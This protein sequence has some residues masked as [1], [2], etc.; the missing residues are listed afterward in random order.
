METV[1]RRFTD[2]DGGQETFWVRFRWHGREIRKSARTSSKAVAQQYLAQL[3]EE[4]RRLDRGGRPRRSYKEALERFC[5]EYLPTLKPATQGRYRSSFKNLGT[6]IDRLY[7]DEITKGRLADYVTARRK[8]KV[9]G[10][11]IRRD[12]AALS[13]LC[14]FAV[15]IDLIETHPLKAFSK[16]HIREGAPRTTYPSDEEIELLVEQAAP[17]MGH[18]I[19]FLAETGMRL[20]EVL[21]LEWPQVSLHRRE[22]RLTKTKT[23]APRTVPL[24]D[25]AYSTLI[26]TPRHPTSPYVFWHSD[27]ARYR[28]FSG[29]F[30]RLAKRVGFRY[31]CHDLRHRFASVFL[32]ATGDLAA[33][34][35]VLGHKSIEMTMRYSHL[36]TEHLH[37]AVKKAGTKLGTR[38]TVSDQHIEKFDATGPVFAPLG[39]TGYRWTTTVKFEKPSNYSLVVPTSTIGS[40]TFQAA[41]LN[42]V[43][44]AVP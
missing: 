1:W 28:Q 23:S 44:S 39:G 15:A 33:L 24:S 43:S 5:A 37:E 26:G 41:V 30:R 19:R 3:L 8:A 31:R 16:R 34:Q 40:G 10:A 2:A 36:L 13:V 17:M 6:H 14:S 25:P 21:S 4:H 20:E 12:L 22:V 38:T 7:L 35:A 29:H 42:P 9:T 18:V 27:G 32:Q 11:T